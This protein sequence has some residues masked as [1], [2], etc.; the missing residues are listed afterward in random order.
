[1]KNITITVEDKLYHAA[2]VRA[3]QRQTNVTAVLRG[4]LR[5]FVQGKATGLSG[6]EDEDRKS[7]EEL[8]RRLSKC[9]LELG[10]RPTREKT[11]A[12]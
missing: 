12:R 5:A 11:Y 1:V 7:R 4:Y 10:Y 6:E 9:K 2:R 8:V 3:A